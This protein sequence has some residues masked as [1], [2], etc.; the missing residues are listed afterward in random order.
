MIKRYDWKP[1]FGIVERREGPYVMYSDHIAALAPL[2]EVR[3]EK[4]AAD[5][6]V[7][8]IEELFPNWKSY[9]DLVDCITSEL[10]E[11]RKHAEGR[12]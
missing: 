3:R 4:R 6:I 12:K 1:E 7:G 2:E 9:R 8:Q 5:Q 10:H 11:L